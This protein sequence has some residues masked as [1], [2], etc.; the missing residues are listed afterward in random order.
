M[1]KPAQ[2]KVRRKKNQKENTL[3]PSDKKNAN[4]AK[5]L[6]KIYRRSLRQAYRNNEELSHKNQNLVRAKKR[7]QKRIE[8]IRKQQERK[9]I[10]SSDTEKESELTI[11]T[12]RSKTKNE[13][14]N[15]GLNRLPLKNTKVRRTLIE[16][17]CKFLLTN[18][19]LSELKD[20]LSIQWKG[21]VRKY[22]CGSKLTKSMGVCRQKVAKL[23]VKW[24]SSA[25]IMNLRK[26]G[27][28]VSR[29]RGQ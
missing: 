1:L 11:M 24:K 14:K 28:S 19:V 10:K 2:L 23:C 29:E 26:K 5:V 4:R 13:M 7:L 8:R 17:I 3:I 21:L 16:E 25:K 27:G 22:R 15:L 6:R 12:P 20:E 9:Q 18:T